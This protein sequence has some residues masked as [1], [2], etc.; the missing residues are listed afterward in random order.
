MSKTAAPK[1]EAHPLADRLPKMTSAEFEALKASI[2][3]RLAR[4]LPPLIHAILLFQ[5]KILDG[6]HRYRACVDLG[7][8]PQFVEFSGDYAA[9]VQH[10][11]D[12]SSHRNMTEGQ[13]ACAAFEF[14]DDLKPKRKRGRPSKTVSGNDTISGKSRDIAALRFG[15]SSTQVA[16]VKEIKEGDAALYGEIFDGRLNV[17]QAKNRL[18]LKNRKREVHKL[19]RS[20]ALSASDA[21]IIEGDCIEAMEAEPEASREIVF[22]D[23]PYNNGWRYNGDPSADRLAPADYVKWCARWMNAATRLLTPTGS[24]FV[25]CDDAYADELGVQLRRIGRLHRQ[26]T[27]VWWE[28][29]GADTKTSLTVCTRYIHHYTRSI[30]WVIN[31]EFRDE[32][33]RQQLGDARAHPDGK[34]PSNVWKIS[35]KQGTANDRVPFADAPPQLPIEIPQRCIL[36]ASS[37]G[38]RV[39]DPFNGNGTTG[40]A[41]LRNHRQYTGIERSPKYAR[42]S[43]QWIAAN[44]QPSERKSA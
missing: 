40:I 42:Q 10:V 43:R 20:L 7:I 25:L 16:Y 26:P 31:P 24:L 17:N 18:K 23:P 35:R 3:D 11:I 27:I 33:A 12:E 4:N 6:R 38:A 13:R 32:S 34:T 1:L 30:E 22:A 21:V 44:L 8:K 14:M 41:A 19:H 28:T 37:P 29:F 36:M 39:L 15:V 2:I 9:A 5:N